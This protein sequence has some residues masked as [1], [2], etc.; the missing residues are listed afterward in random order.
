M[1]NAVTVFFLLIFAACQQAP[2][3]AAASLAMATAQAESP[4]KQSTD[5]AFA[6]FADYW[7]AGEAEIS[8]YELAQARYGEIHQGEAALVFVTEPFSKSKQ[9]KL[10]NPATRDKVDVLKLNM[11]KKFFTGVYPYSMM[12][13]AFKPVDM[14]KALSSLKVATSSQEWCGH[15]FT[16]YNLSGKQYEVKQFSYF[17]SE[18]DMSLKL[19]AT[20]MEDDI[21]TQIRL[22]PGLLPTGQFEMI[23]GSMYSR[24]SHREIAAETVRA[25]RSDLGNGLSNY[26]V[27]FPNQR[28]LSITFQSTFP[29]SIETWQETYLSGFGSNAREL[30][31]IATLKKRIKLDYWNHNGLS[32]SEYR[33]KLELKSW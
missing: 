25:E 23:P 26:I 21:W 27:K 6:R 17:E 5:P 14:K 29:Y 8:T 10:D 4:V 9:V 2:E 32:D 20:F 13:S 31:T 24:L 15:T 16:Q 30:T 1:K 19:P 3:P 28:S 7:F 12:M 33:D 22:N 11:T 18:G